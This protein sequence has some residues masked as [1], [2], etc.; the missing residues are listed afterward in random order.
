MNPLSHFSPTKRRSA[1][2]AGVFGLALTSVLLLCGA[3]SMPVENLLPQ[4]TMQGDLDAGGHNLTNAATVSA[5]AVN[6]SALNA[7]TLSASTANATT[8]NSTTINAANLTVS[9]S[10]SSPS[11][12]PFLLGPTNHN[13]VFVGDSITEGPGG[14]PATASQSFAAVLQYLGLGEAGGT[15]MYDLG[16]RQETTSEVAGQY[17]SSG[18]GAITTTIT[19]TSGSTT[20]TVA[21]A[22]GIA[23]GMCIGSANT[24]PNTML[25]IS[26][27][28]VT[29]SQKATA[30]GSVTCSIASAPTNL[31]YGEL[32]PGSAANDWQNFHGTAHMLSPAI[33][34]LSGDLVI[35]L[36]NNDYYENTSATTTLTCSTASGSPYVT[37]TSGSFSGLVAGLVLTGTGL[38]SSPP[39]TILRGA[40]TAN[41]TLSAN[42]TATGSATITVHYPTTSLA[43]WEASYSG[44][45]SAAHADGYMVTALTLLSEGNAAQGSAISNVFR[46]EFNAYLSANTGGAD[47]VF[48]LT[49]VLPPYGSVVG[50]PYYFT[51]SDH[52]SVLGC[53]QVGRFL[54]QQFFLKEYTAQLAWNPFAS[55]LLADSWLSANIPR[56]NQPNIFKPDN[57][58]VTSTTANLTSGSATAT[59]TGLT[60]GIYPGMYVN[61]SFAGNAFNPVT[62]VSSI[63]GATLTLT[64]TANRTASNAA[65]NFGYTQFPGANV[66]K[67]DI[68]LGPCLDTTAAGMA[69]I[70]FTSQGDAFS[71][72]L[73]WQNTSGLANWSFTANTSGGGEM[74]LGQNTGASLFLPWN[75]AWTADS[76]GVTSTSFQVLSHNAFYNPQLDINRANGYN[77]DSL[78][79]DGTNFTISETGS[80]TPNAG[81]WLSE[82]ESTGAVAFKSDVTASG[83]NLISDTAGKGLQVK[84][85]SNAKQGTATLSGGAVTVSDSSVTANSRILLTTQ[86][87]G[88]TVGVPYVSTRT[89]GTSFTI[90]STSGSDTSTV[91]YEIFE[92]AP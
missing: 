51:D 27:T 47:Y 22:T 2:L 58:V 81:T 78:K 45:I 28:T 73:V 26:G 10:L 31:F 4:G 12:V 23:N 50:S 43:S 67:N 6:A 70:F 52:L 19:T 62:Q 36:G 61:S 91:A 13:F 29:L 92:P 68:Y 42:A 5:A 38:P 35:L 20:A 11:N 83:G 8:V 7:T 59:I 89:A 53:A 16:F 48:D 66:F 1:T 9:G 76:N 44:L 25:T 86:A 15:T 87:P 49:S 69:N 88:G 21:S 54:N 46:Q 84:E 57:A 60:N 56:L 85:G 79:V 32:Y 55:G 40:G 74:L 37:V 18:T 77:R 41:L 90:T 34:G 63:S 39:P 33:S 3:G 14:T 30:T 65:L 82:T 75:G 72:G 64:S 71:P 80:N 17:S 24:A